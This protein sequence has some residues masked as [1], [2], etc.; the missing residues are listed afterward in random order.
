MVKSRFILDC[1]YTKTTCLL[2]RLFP[3]AETVL[4]AGR[5]GQ[6]LD[7]SAFKRNS[8]QLSP[9]AAT[10]T[11]DKFNSFVTEKPAHSPVKILD[12]LPGCGNPGAEKPGNFLNSRSFTWRARDGTVPFSHC[13][14]Q[15][16]NIKK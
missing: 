14:H 1:C 2:T 6:R 15:S 11:T 16:T 13:P 12:Y 4:T 3:L 8:G 9:V 10:S 5:S 7:I